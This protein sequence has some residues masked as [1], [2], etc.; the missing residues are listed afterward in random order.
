MI[1]NNGEF[2]KNLNVENYNPGIQMGDNSGNCGNR[3]VNNN[4]Q[5]QNTINNFGNSGKTVE[6]TVPPKL[7]FEL[8]ENPNDKGLSGVP[9][10]E[11]KYCI[12]CHN[13][14]KEAIK[15]IGIS[16]KDEQETICDCS[17]LPDKVDPIIKPFE[18]APHSITFSELDKI[19]EYYEKKQ[20]EE[21]TIVV[22]II[23]GTYSYKLDL[24]KLGD[25]GSTRRKA[26][27]KIYG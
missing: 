25:G 10:G 7:R 15:I 23:E 4:T 12:L 16:L 27:R 26:M 24:T 19:G 5:I 1:N 17:K 6:E 9:I 22:E 8:D 14:N 11:S 20:I 2:N 21:C 3:I 13:D 18:S